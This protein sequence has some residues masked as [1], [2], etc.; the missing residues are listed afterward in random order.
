M[1]ERPFPG[2]QGKLAIPYPH[3]MPFPGQ[4]DRRGLQG[5]PKGLKGL[6]TQGFSNVPIHSRIPP[7]MLE[8]HLHAHRIIGYAGDHEDGQFG[9]LPAKKGEQLRAHYSISEAEVEQDKIKFIEP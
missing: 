9:T 1:K 7:S 6:L 2:F 4:K 5:I 8:N 3:E